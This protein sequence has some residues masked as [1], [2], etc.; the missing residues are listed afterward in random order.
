MNTSAYLTGFVRV[1]SLVLGQSHDTMEV[2]QHHY[3]DAIMGAIVSQIT[4]LM[5]WMKPFIKAHIKENIE[6]PCQWS[7][8]RKMFQFDDVIMIK[9]IP[10][11]KTATQWHWRVHS[12]SDMAKF[13][14]Y[15][16]FKIIACYCFQVRNLHY[17][18]AI[19]GTAESLIQPFIQTQIK[20][21]IKA[22]RHWP[23]CGEFTGTGEFPAQRASYAENVSIWW[24][25]HD[26]PSRTIS[27]TCTVWCRYDTDIFPHPHSSPVIYSISQE[28]CTRFLL[29]CALLWLYIDWFSHIHQAYFTGTVAI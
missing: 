15:Q 22:P 7:V 20:V 29:C 25:H 17:C 10:I 19:M 21:N 11:A 13:I 23:L 24:R 3:N 18:D 14:R 5:M 8:M 27:W 4:G 28:I 26:T 16:L 9:A 2:Y 12:K 6:A 1:T